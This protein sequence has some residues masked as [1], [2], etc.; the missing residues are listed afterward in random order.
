M[1]KDIIAK[2]DSRKVGQEMYQLIEKLYP[3]CRSIT[4]DGLRD[5]LKVI[6]KIVPIKIH[7]VPSG[8]KVFDW[9]IPEEWN[10]KDAYVK[11]SRG[12]KI[13][14]FKK[15]NLH[16]LN[17]SAPIKK[18]VRLSELKKHLYT[19]SDQPDAIPYLASYYKKQWGFC[20][21][22]NQFKK[23]R[24]DVYDVFI[25][26][27]HKKGHLTYGELFIKGYK[28]DE[29]L[30][31]TYICHPSLCN[32]NLSGITLLTFLAK[33]LLKRKLEYSYRFL[34]IPETIG[35]ITWLS[36]N[37]NKVSNIKH[38]LIV[39]CVG[40]AGNL[41][42]KKSRDGNNIIDKAVEKILI[43]S[44]DKYKVLDFFPTGSDERQFCS[45]GFN[46]PIGSLM[47]TPYG[48]FKEYHT[49]KDNLNFVKPKYLADSFK[50]YLQ[51]I[52]LIENNHAYLNLNQYCEPQLGKRGI[53]ES[54]GARK[55]GAI[56][57]VA[58]LWVLNLSDG[59]NSLLDIAMRSGIA[60]NDILTAV[61][62]LIEH[63]ILKQKKHKK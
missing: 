7:N 4:G 48:H 14:D 41:T 12:K 35:S 47:R 63:K 39:T 52:Q 23:L 59:N 50:K 19:L 44:K 55:K 18:R 40:D 43:D 13:I 17:Y 61:N 33:K 11:N 56:N 9:I 20:L 6:K 21:S 60:F 29:M 36:L 51:I 37:K 2:L 15:S 54:L 31:S 5:T 28:A 1:K 25:D 24:D 32:D 42:Y 57:E 30:L 53:Y 8:T 45:P 58:M 46:L 27:S 3:I 38:G 10:I 62:I 49:S 34:F 22:Y 16:V 26:A